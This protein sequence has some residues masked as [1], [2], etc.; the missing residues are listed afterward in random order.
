[1]FIVAPSLTSA[2]DKNEARNVTFDCK[3][4]ENGAVAMGSLILVKQDGTRISHTCKPG[5]VVQ[6]GQYQATLS[7]DGVLDAPTIV[8]AIKIG[9]GGQNEIHGNFITGMLE[10]RTSIQ[11]QPCAGK[12]R[13]LKNKNL[14]ATVGSAVR[15]KMSAANY[16]VEV[17]CRDKA[18][19]IEDVQ[20]TQGQTKQLDVA[21]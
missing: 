16:R 17:S 9:T 11:T 14:V 20:V 2:A 10:V 4:T 18:K 8:Q 5:L 21:L 6:T 13:I 3:I 12:I 1:M 7:I 19:T 15:N